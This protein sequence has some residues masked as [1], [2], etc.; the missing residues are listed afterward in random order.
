MIGMGAEASTIVRAEESDFFS[1]CGAVKIPS[2]ERVGDVPG[3]YNVLTC[4]FFFFFANKS[5]A[6]T[7]SAYGETMAATETFQINVIN[8]SYSRA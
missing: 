8:L 2:G 3:N 4:H 5:Y 1:D 7:A 6:S